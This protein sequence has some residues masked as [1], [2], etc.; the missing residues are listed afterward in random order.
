MKKMLSCGAQDM[1][2]AAIIQKRRLNLVGSDDT[3]AVVSYPKIIPVD[4]TTDAGQE[5]LVFMTSDNQGGIIR[6]T[7]NTALIQSF[8]ADDFLDPRIIY[9]QDF[10]GGCDT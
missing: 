1:L 2:E 9:H 4:I 8:E 7:I 6:L 10:D 5:Q 3:G